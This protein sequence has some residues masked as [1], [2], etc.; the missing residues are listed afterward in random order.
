MTEYYFPHGDMLT[1]AIIVEDPIYL[2]E[3]LVR[4]ATFKRDPTL[5]VPAL[6]PFEVA[7]E[8]P[9][10]EKGQ[11]PAYPLGTKHRE[12][13]DRHHL[14][15]E[16]SQ[17]GAQTMYPEYVKRLEELMKAPTPTSTSASRQ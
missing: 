10:L 12:Y 4:T 13:A 11:V 1:L 14:P 5:T 15:F 17:G 8:L 16:A 2:T 3:P 6:Q 7:E 9:S